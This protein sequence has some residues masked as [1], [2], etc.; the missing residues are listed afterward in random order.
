VIRYGIAGLGYIGRTHLAAAAKVAGV[1]VVAA[2]DQAAES[3][4]PRFPELRVYPDAEELFS[5]SEIDAVIIC[6]P[7]WLHE[8][9]TIAAAE[10]GKHVLCEKPFALDAAQASRMLAASRK[11]GAK[12][13]IAQV[14][15][16]WPHYVRMVELVRSGAVGNVQSIS[17]WRL[18]AYPSWS[19]WFRNPQ[20]SGG[21]LLD[22]QIHDLD[23]VYWLLGAPEAV[24]TIAVRSAAGSPDHVFT[25][26]RYRQQI[27]HIEASYLMPE[28]WPFQTGMRVHGTEGCLAYS[29]AVEGNIQERAQAAHRFAIHRPNMDAGEID[30]EPAD[31]FVEQLRYFTRQL[32]EG[33]TPERCP[34]EDSLAVMRIA[35]A[36]EVSASTG[37]FIDP[38]L[39]MHSMA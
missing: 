3:I 30:V 21:C 12:L 16:F 11:S 13:M 36:S 6:V 19:S 33:G 37:G 18:A 25:T 34:P 1:R 35:G 10:A 31:P 2:C 20:Q 7:T 23:I 8:R 28:R 4:R 22:L 39:A 17:A 27:A 32:E 24:F 14:L 15:R 29:F 9:Y 26:L 5:D 38:S